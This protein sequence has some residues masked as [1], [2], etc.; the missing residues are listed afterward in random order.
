MRGLIEKVI[1]QALFEARSRN[2]PVYT[3]ALYYDHESPAISVC[4]DT[5]EQSK[6]APRSV[7]PS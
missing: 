7:A 4:V 2:V 3:F 1:D 5:E 6:A